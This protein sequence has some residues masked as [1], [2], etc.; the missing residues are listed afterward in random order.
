[1]RKILATVA[2]LAAVAKSVPLDNGVDQSQSKMLLQL[3][4]RDTETCQGLGDD[5]K[6][7]YGCKDA[8]C[9]QQVC[10]EGLACKYKEYGDKTGVCKKDYLDY[11]KMHQGRRRL[12]QEGWACVLRHVAEV[13]KLLLQRP[14]MLLKCMQVK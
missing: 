8:A 10:C 3:M 11:D 4:K 14:D 13:C 12:R 7:P 6:N 1:M 5:C 2:L 9:A